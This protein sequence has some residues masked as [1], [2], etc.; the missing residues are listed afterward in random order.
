MKPSGNITGPI[1]LIYASFNKKN[2]TAIVTTEKRQFAMC[3]NV[4]RVQYIGHTANQLFAVCLHENTREIKE[5]SANCDVRRVRGPGTWQ[6]P[7]FAVCRY[8][9]TRRNWSTCHARAP[10]VRR[11]P[12]P[13]GL[14]S[15]GREGNEHMQKKKKELRNKMLLYLLFLKKIALELHITMNLN[16]E[17]RSNK[18]KPNNKTYYTESRSQFSQT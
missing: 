15:N 6:T 16:L 4:C 2:R 18:H 7:S 3:P 13:D 10:A 5:H 11:R 12:R 14:V 1:P 9:V 17:D 8:L